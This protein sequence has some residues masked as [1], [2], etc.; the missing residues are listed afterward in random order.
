MK[1]TPA[2]YSNYNSSFKNKASLKAVLSSTATKG[3]V[4][5][6]AQVVTKQYLDYLKLPQIQFSF[7]ELEKLFSIN[8]NIEFI[9]SSYKS[10]IKKMNI[11]SELAP[12][13]VFEEVDLPYAFGYESSKNNIVVN[14]MYELSDKKDFLALLR[15]EL[16]HFLQ[17]INLL[18]HENLGKKYFDNICRLN[19]ID[20]SNFIQVKLLENP[21]DWDVD[22]KT[23]KE[24]YQM[25]K[26]LE[27]NDIE[28]Y[29][30][31][32]NKE[33]KLNKK[34]LKSFQRKII[35]NLGVIKS[36]SAETKNL[37]KIFDSLKNY[38][39]NDSWGDYLTKRAEYE[40]HLAEY[41][42]EAEVDRACFVQL[43]KEKYQSF[44]TSK[45]PQD[46]R[47]RME[48]EEKLRENPKT[49]FVLPNCFS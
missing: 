7:A 1:I 27:N 20:T 18:R 35:K 10:L 8:D 5:P 26:Y 40:A 15:H 14:T 4:S 3:K 24:L 36:D 43:L 46:I 39:I 38:T 30:K 2:N 12:K 42:M 37:E 23:F 6:L 25:K 49:D 28:S 47:I 17:S 9:K 22:Y 45:N 44:I 31:E 41:A 13:L 11:P 16:Q 21:S 29:K 19:A 33:N 32:V 34:Y 48:V